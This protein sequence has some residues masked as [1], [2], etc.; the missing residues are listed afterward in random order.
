MCHFDADYVAL[1]YRYKDPDGRLYPQG[2]L[3]GP[4]QPEDQQVNPGAG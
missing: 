3:T 2:D 4:E 1:E